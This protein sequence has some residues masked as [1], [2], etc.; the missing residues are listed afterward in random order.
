MPIEQPPHLSPD[1][2]RTDRAAGDPSDALALHVWHRPA[3]FTADFA[4]Q[5]GLSARAL[6]IAGWVIY[7]VVFLLF[8]TGHYWL[9]LLAAVAF[10]VLDLAA[11]N[12]DQTRGSSEWTKRGVGLLLPL[13]WWWAWSHGLDAYG[14]PLEPVYQASLLAVIV[15]ATLADG[16]IH[17][18]FERRFRPMRM[19]DW[20]PVDTRFRLIS[21]G[22][23]TNLV[24]LAGSLLFGRPDSGLELVGLWTLLSLIF[25]AVRYAQASA[26]RDRG[27]PV[28]SW[29]R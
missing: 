14:A 1:A 19:R 22:R 23:D 16:I 3:R 27:Q 26:A 25:H 8:W 9:G 17:I 4:T 7:A 21:A 18:L 12:L 20:R 15:L 29:L 24:I 2:P 5:A 28:R 10:A 13:L 6:M 11:D